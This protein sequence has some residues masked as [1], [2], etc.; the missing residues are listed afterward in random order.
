MLQ[1]AVC[2]GVAFDAFSFSA[3]RLGPAEVD[4]GRCEVVDALV[5]TDTGHFARRSGRYRARVGPGRIHC[6]LG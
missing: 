1:A 4:T 2:D 6:A 3:D 5:I